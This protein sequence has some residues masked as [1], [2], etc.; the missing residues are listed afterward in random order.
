M[1]DQQPILVN[2]MVGRVPLIGSFS[3]VQLLSVLG[4]FFLGYLVY[5]NTGNL[6]MALGAWVW[7]FFTLV[8][9]LGKH[10]WQYVNKYRKSSRWSKG[11]QTFRNPLRRRGRNHGQ[12]N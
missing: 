2:R 5:S 7:T 9:V 11:R 10:H 12:E 4:G 3:P 1:K 6:V 8:L